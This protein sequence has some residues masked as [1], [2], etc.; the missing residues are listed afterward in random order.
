MSENCQ[1]KSLA[2][3]HYIIGYS[4]IECLHAQL[5]TPKVQ[6]TKCVHV[7]PSKF[8]LLLEIGPRMLREYAS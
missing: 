4:H 1:T 2:Q 6:K 8:S 7:P 3:P 5:I